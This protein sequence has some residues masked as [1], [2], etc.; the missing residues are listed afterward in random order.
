MVYGLVFLAMFP[1]VSSADERFDGSWDVIA[2]ETDGKRMDEFNFAGMQWRFE[3]KRIEIKPAG[4]SPARDCRQ[5]IASLSIR[6]QRQA[7][8]PS[9]RLDL[10][11]IGWRESQTDQSD[12]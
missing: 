9:F 6:I 12:L 5:A 3:G 11:E 2:A 4:A 10:V 1:L 7:E 8:S